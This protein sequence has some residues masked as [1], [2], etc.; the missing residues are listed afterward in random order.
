MEDTSLEEF[1]INADAIREKRNAGG[2][3]LYDLIFDMTKK[4]MD[5][6][7][8]S[9]RECAKNTYDEHQNSNEFL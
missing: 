5:K 4:C 6:T 1:S 9:D 2:S 3:A 7:S 8:V